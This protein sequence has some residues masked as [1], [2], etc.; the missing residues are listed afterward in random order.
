M[1]IFMGIK[2]MIDLFLH[3]ASLLIFLHELK[4]SVQVYKLS[5][6]LEPIVYADTQN[7]IS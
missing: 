4:A 1:Q 6:I 2:Y 7:Q 5:V 3:I